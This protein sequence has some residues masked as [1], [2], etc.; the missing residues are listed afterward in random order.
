MINGKYHKTIMIENLL[1][2]MT[3]TQLKKKILI[4]KLIKTS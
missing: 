2:V 4:L 3:D 1:N